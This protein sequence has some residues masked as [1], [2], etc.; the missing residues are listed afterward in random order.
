MKRVVG[1][2]SIL[3]FVV[4]ASGCGGGDS[5]SASAPVSATPGS[6]VTSTSTSTSVP[7][8]ATSGPYGVE[9]LVFDYLRRPIAASVNLWVDVGRGGY[10]WWWANGRLAADV[11]GRLVAQNLPTSIARITAFADGFRQPCAVAVNIPQDRPVDVELLTVASLDTQNPPR[12]LTAVDRFLSGK[13]YEIAG[14]VRTPV[15]GAELW[16]EYVPDDT[17]ANTRSDLGGGYFFCNLPSPV[18]LYVRK[19]GFRDTAVGPLDLAASRELDVELR[20]E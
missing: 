16:V 15:S 20:R 8:F 9:G 3:A 10:S 12:P 1:S 7:P 19:S 6:S 11:G 5:G 13:L 14:G 18:W 4:L 2:S 17:T